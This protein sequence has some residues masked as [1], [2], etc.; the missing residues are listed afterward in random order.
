MTRQERMTGNCNQRGEAMGKKGSLIFALFILMNGIFIS[1]GY[2]TVQTFAAGKA[3]TFTGTWVA[4]GIR[5]SV[6]FG[7]NRQTALFK[8]TGHVNLKDTV[9][10]QKDY[11]SECIGLADS[12]TG[13]IARCVWRS[14]DDQEVYITLKGEKFG[15]GSK[16]TGEIIGGTGAAAGISGTLQFEWS[17]MSFQTNNNI[18]TLGGYAKNLSGSFQLP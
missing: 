13:S 8:F 14:L 6:P 9:G 11:W 16:V 17:S 3:G 12:Q 7:K 18:T 10:K 15:K 5:D 4:D 2:F 1:F